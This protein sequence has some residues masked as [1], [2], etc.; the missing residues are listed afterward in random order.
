MPSHR[1]IPRYDS[2]GHR[3]CYIDAE[4]A[5]R[6]CADG[7]HL[8]VCVSCGTSKGEGRC[9]VA[10]NHTFAVFDAAVEEE[11]TGQ[12]AQNAAPPDPKETPPAGPQ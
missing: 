5:R 2:S 3:L 9:L 6:L 10:A 12:R 11:E 7:S 1:N 8:F 4:E